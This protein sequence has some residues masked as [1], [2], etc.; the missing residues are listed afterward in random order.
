MRGG[1][2][3]IFS[4]VPHDQK[5][6]KSDDSTNHIFVPNFILKKEGEGESGRHF[7]KSVHVFL[8]GVHLSLQ[9]TRPSLLL[10]R[11]PMLRSYKSS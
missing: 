9:L 1:L 6:T 8:G 5:K 11:R 3:R 7:M 2:S 10:R 4:Q